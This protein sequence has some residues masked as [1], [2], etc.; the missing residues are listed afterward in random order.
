MP[1]ESVPPHASAVTSKLGLRMLSFLAF[2]PIAPCSEVLT[3]RQTRLGFSS[4][5]LRNFYALV[6]L[7]RH[8]N[9]TGAT[10]SRG[11]MGTKIE[12]QQ[13]PTAG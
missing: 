9:M 6:N 5:G 2:R 8:P 3:K 7:G 12:P 10:S 11:G 1:P 4:Y 13:T